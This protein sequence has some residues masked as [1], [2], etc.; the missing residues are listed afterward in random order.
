MNLSDVAE[1]EE[2]PE[3]EFPHHADIAGI[4]TSGF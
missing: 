1:V 4:F 3:P 2:L